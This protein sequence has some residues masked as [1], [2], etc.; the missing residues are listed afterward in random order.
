MIKVSLKYDGKLVDSVII[1]GHAFYDDYGK[2]I[3][4]ASVSS[5]VITTINAILRIDSDSIDYLNNNGIKISVLSHNKVTDTLI[6][7]MVCLLKD[8]QKQYKKNVTIEEVSR[9]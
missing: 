6:E 1:S 9:C 2:D 5:I 4:C 3:V 7:N 8:L